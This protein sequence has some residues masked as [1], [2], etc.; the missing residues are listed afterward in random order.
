[1]RQL[2]I[3]VPLAALV[4]IVM[5]GSTPGSADPYAPGVVP[6]VKAPASVPAGSPIVITGSGFIPLEQIRIY[7]SN[8]AAAGARYQPP[9]RETRDDV[10]MPVAY[11]APAVP[12]VAQGTLVG[13]TTAN[14]G[15][16]FSF[17]L[18][19]GTP[20]VPTSGVVN[21]AAVGVQSLTDVR[22]NVT[23]VGLAA[24]ATTPAPAGGQA[25]GMPPTGTNGSVL[26]RQ[27]LIAVAA[28]TVGALLVW[29]TIPARRRRRQSQPNA[30]DIG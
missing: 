10:M 17:T 5:F 15:G 2:R 23:V 20:G 29:F 26:L 30:T 8:S 4:G 21:L 13:T 7:V 22:F 9:A 25:G 1:M 27:L 3:L 11:V 24:A 28:I 6:E 14:V 19:A 12:P 18:A 16:S